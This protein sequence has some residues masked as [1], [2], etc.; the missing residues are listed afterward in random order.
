MLLVTILT[1]VQAPPCRRYLEFQMASCR[2]LSFQQNTWPTCIVRDFEVC[3]DVCEIWPIKGENITGWLTSSKRSILSGQ[4][5]LSSTRQEG[6]LLPSIRAYHSVNIWRQPLASLYL[7]TKVTM[8]QWILVLTTFLVLSLHYNVNKYPANVAFR[9]G[10]S[11]IPAHVPLLDNNLDHCPFGA[12]QAA[13]VFLPSLWYTP[14]PENPWT[15][16]VTKQPTSEVRTVLDHE[17]IIRG[18]THSLANNVDV[19]FVD[20]LRNFM[21]YA[22]GMRHGEDLITIDLFR[23]RDAGL[24][25]MFILRWNGWIRN[26]IQRC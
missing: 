7:P 22:G 2:R 18:L 5:K 20:D 10:H 15:D 26:R 17:S 24:P 12:I 13:A 11:A 14:D 8:I 6:G 1:E 21:T 25:S 23:S 19:S 3:P 9:Y 4:P 16:P